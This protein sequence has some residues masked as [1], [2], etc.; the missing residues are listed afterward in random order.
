MGLDCRFEIPIGLKYNLCL[1]YMKL[2]TYLMN[3]TR[4][5]FVHIGADY[6][7]RTGTYMAALE[8][9]GWDLRMDFIYIHHSSTTYDYTDIKGELYGL[10]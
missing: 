9:F 7:V 10:I 4:R 1:V 5:E 2:S 6:P 3:S 8:T